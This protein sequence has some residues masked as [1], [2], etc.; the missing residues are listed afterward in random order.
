MIML[1]TTPP[2]L[3]WGTALGGFALAALLLPL[4]PTWAQRSPE[5]PQTATFTY[6]IKADHEA[7]P[8]EDSKTDVRVVVATDGA[9]EQIQADS[10]D[11]AA[12]LIKQKVD[13]IA[14]QG[15]GPEKQAA[16]IKLLKQALEDL[17]KARAKAVS[18]DGSKDPAKKQERFLVRRGEEFFPA[19]T[20]E[21]KA[22]IDKAKSR[23]DALRKELD[24]KRLQLTK[25]QRDLEQLVASVARWEIL[26]DEPQTK[27]PLER[28]T[29]RQRA[30]LPESP[31]QPKSAT[32]LS[33]SDKDRLESLEKKLA[34]LLDEVASLKK[35]EAK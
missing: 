5:K 28:V 13:V 20:A 16:Q 4:S 10:L 27:K 25:A 21:K 9:V 29:V 17:E 18:S 8:A 3:G 14:K 35:H 2:R 19:I 7:K 12:E 11:K 23:I 32:T 1:G 22:K 6:E 24:E 26:V 15:G 30:L 34:K 33:P 31:E